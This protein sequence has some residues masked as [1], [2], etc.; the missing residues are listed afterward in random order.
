MERVAVA[1]GDAPFRLRRAVGLAAIVASAVAGEY[2]AGINF[3]AVQSLGVYPE[4][5]DL[6]PLAMF[7]TGLLLITKVHLFARFSAVMPRA[8]SAYVWIVR[9][10]NLPAGFIASFLWWISVTAAMGFIAFAFTTFLGQALSGFGLPAAAVTAP[11][12]R[13][14]IGL[15][16]IWAIYALHASGVAHYGRFVVALLGLIVLTALVIAVYG[17]TATPDRFAALVAAR[18]GLH[19]VP[20]ASTQP[21]SFAAFVSVCSLFVFAYGGVSAAPALGGEAKEASRIMP[22]GIVLG[23]LV[24]LVLYTLVAAAL[25]HAAPW[26][27]VVGLIHSKQ[28]GFATAP[29]L[30]GVLA[31]HWLA[32]LLNLAV[33]VIVGKTLG[34][35][36]LTTSRIVFAW[37]QDRVLPACF[38]STSARG[39]PVAALLL[40]SVLASLFLVQTVFVGWALGVV[41][42]SVS[43]LIVWLFVALGALNLSRNPRFA[44]QNWAR[45][46]IGDKGVIAASLASIVI[47]LALIY[48]VAVLPKTPLLFQPL[49]QTLVASVV[50]V[51]LL[52]RAHRAAAARGE[53]LH[54]ALLEPPLE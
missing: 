24:A 45:G 53:N 16:A 18:T 23:W 6:V 40:T 27:V 32:A 31:P 13:L 33:A 3:V 47:T 50:A 42:R 38:A 29:G 14:V 36:L 25:F 10:L 1:G 12:G 41:I 21:A 46:L 51:L 52:V 17:F 7:V 34:P 11:F 8:G 30:V 26:W 37:G 9:S 5:H 43:L 19:L 20:P 39:A 4:V 15:A 48:A 22:R 49:F 2:G 28:T 44:Q 35:Q 54:L